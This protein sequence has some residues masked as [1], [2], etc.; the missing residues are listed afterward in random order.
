MKTRHLGFAVAAFLLCCVSAF[1]QGLVVVHDPTKEVVETKLSS[2]DEAI[3][4]SA[5]PP[6]RKKISSDV[7][8]GEIEVAGFASGAF[9]KAGVKQT[10]VFYQYCQT[11]NGFGWV[12]LVLIDGGKVEGNFIAEAGWTVGINLIPDINQ[13]GVDEFALAYSGGMH[14]GMGGVGVDV[15]EF[16]NGV[17]KGLG[18][19]KAEEFGPTE[20]ITKWKLSAKPA[21]SPIF[22]K[23]KYFSGEGQDFKRIGTNGIAK[24]TKVNAE[25]MV[26]K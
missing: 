12:G 13:N 18:W 26:V 7:C 11:G 22:Y 6:V 14:Q 21:A 3:F 16:S 5:L 19:Y 23:Q 15:M 8:A 25:F 2:A 24:L 10:L 17:P 20:A 4:N 1:P 9:T